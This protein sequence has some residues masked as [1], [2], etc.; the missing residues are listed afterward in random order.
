MLSSSYRPGRS[1]GVRSESTSRLRRPGRSPP[2]E[3]PRQ[4]QS[5]RR[6]GM[7]AE[8]LGR[9]RDETEDEA[10]SVPVGVTL[11]TRVARC[12]RLAVDVRAK[13]CKV[14]ALD[15]Y[16][17]MPRVGCWTSSSSASRS[18]PSPPAIIVGGLELS[19]TD[20]LHSLASI[21]RISL[22]LSMPGTFGDESVCCFATPLTRTPA[23][24]ASLASLLLS[25]RSP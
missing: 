23:S 2:L 21:V 4:K 25:H 20:L 1:L 11:A 9:L 17:A 13:V 19:S 3:T 18:P 22:A 24:D 8:S 12:G 7:E 6:N 15:G 5:P 16:A 10:E 14:R